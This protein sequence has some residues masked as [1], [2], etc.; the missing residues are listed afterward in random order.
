MPGL[1]D[2]FEYAARPPAPSPF[3]SIALP[4]QLHVPCVI[5]AG[6][7]P[8]PEIAARATDS[9][10]AAGEPLTDPHPA[11]RYM[12]L[13]PTAGKIVGMGRTCLLRGQSIPAV[14]F[15]PALPAPPRPTVQAA[16]LLQRVRES[17]FPQWI[18][19]LRGSGI[20]A[21]RWSSPDLVEQLHLCLRRPVDTVICNILDLDRAVPIQAKTAE[22]W[23]KDVVAGVRALASL[24][25][26]GRAWLAVPGDLPPECAAAVREAIAGTDVRYVPCDNRY[27]LAHPSLLLRSLTGRLLRFGSLPPEQGILLLDAAAALAVG[28]FFLYAEP[29]LDLPIG[30]IDQR[31]RLAKFLSVPIGTPLAHLL[32]QIGIAEQWETLSAGTPLHERSLSIDCVVGGGELTIYAAPRGSDVNPE[33]CIRCAWCIEACPVAI[34][35]AALL[36]AAQLHDLDYADRYGLAACIECGICSYV[37]P[38]HLPLLQGIRVLRRPAGVG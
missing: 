28:R 5:D 20:W 23:T 13:A 29:M 25:G 2:P 10:L 34:Q 4:P 32:E 15:E 6:N 7:G 30:V 36:E 22:T 37:C 17:S 21:S 11:L 33:P 9:T 24:S 12:P 38:S 16:D 27:P 26:A 1:S 8:V 18:D 14:I 3:G 31:N 35:P 19:R